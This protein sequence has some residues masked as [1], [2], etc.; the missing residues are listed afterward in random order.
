[1]VHH[2]LWGDEIHSWNIAKASGTL[3]E[4]FSN[5]RYEGHPPVWYL[6]LFAISKATHNPLYMQWAHVVICGALAFLLLFYSKFSLLH[7]VLILAG[8]YFSFEYAAIS[9]NYAFGILIAFMICIIVP[10]QF[11]YKHILYYILVLILA[12]THLLG[13]ILA[14]SFHAYFLRLCKKD[15]LILHCLLGAM[16][17]LPAIYFIL[18][19]SNNNITP[20]LF[21][22]MFSR[23]Q[24]LTVMQAPTK[25]FLPIPAWWFSN[26][27]N[28]HF[29]VD[30]GNSF[31]L[32]IYAIPFI[33][34]SIL[35]TVVY[36]F[37]PNRNILYFFILNLGVTLFIGFIF[38]LSSARY[39]GY[40]YISFIAG[41]W[42]M[43]DVA[44]D[45][46]KP[47]VTAVTVLL[48]CQLIGTGIALKNDWTRPFS[49]IH[50]IAQIAA[51]IPSMEK[52]ITDFWCLNYLAASLDEPFYCV[53]FEKEK[54]FLVWDSHSTAVNTNP[55]LYI[56]G[57]KTYLQKHHSEHCYVFSNNSLQT[58]IEKDP[59]ITNTFHIEVLAQEDNAIEKY[60]NIYLFKFTLANHHETR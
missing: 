55:Q 21:Q 15:A 52:P 26:F 47:K 20:S 38:P 29:L 27:W 60:S 23:E 44:G 37:W 28:T 45:L 24:L 59:A 10:K 48:S 42:L 51:T 16:M 1:M 56:R 8:Y 46:P 2:E 18:P 25:A 33:S 12:N 39:V 41:L 53:G 4:L 40:L 17:I 19:P 5:T 13:F 57:I 9:R 7:K 58:I 54:S 6:I 3:S 32:F 36:L 11:R 34:A 31:K 43:K 49:Q 30:A 50:K 14:L 35:A 22:H